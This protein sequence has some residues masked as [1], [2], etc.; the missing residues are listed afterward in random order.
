MPRSSG[1]PDN[2]IIN[3][4]SEKARRETDRGKTDNRPF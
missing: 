3:R 2:R 4:V 1:G